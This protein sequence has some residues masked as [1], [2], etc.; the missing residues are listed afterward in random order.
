MLLLVSLLAVCG[1]LSEGSQT[2]L[3]HSLGQAGT[4]QKDMFFAIEM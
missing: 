2:H 1:M 3:L 4:Q